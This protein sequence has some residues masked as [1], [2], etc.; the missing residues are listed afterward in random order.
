MKTKIQD[1][2]KKIKNDNSLEGT[3]RLEA[4]SDGVIAIVITLLIF[5]IK[6]PVINEFSNAGV[7][8]AIVGI[9]PNLVGFLVSFVTVAIF[10]V[11]HHHFFHAIIKSDAGLLWYNNH[12]LFW[13]TIIPFATAFLGNYPTIPLVIAMYG[14]VLFMAALAFLVMNWHVSFKTNL[15]PESVSYEV[16]LK[17][18]RRAFLGVIV[19]GLAVPAVFIHPYISYAIFIMVPLY[20]FLPTRIHVAMGTDEVFKE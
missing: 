14:F 2:N 6:V 3:T 9:L 18:F 12:L 1:L 4:F 5:E 20:Y 8:N 16:K 7:I 15:L 17:E 19:Y 13:I 11:N 10:W